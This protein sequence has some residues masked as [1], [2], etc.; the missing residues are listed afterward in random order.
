MSGNEIYVRTLNL[1]GDFHQIA[2]QLDE[3]A[4]TVF[5]IT[6]PEREIV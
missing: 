5:G 4:E 3:I 6:K 2:G 1:N